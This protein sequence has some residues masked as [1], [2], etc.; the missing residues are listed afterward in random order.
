MTTKKPKRAVEWARCPLVLVE[1]IGRSLKM[2]EVLAGLR[3]VCAAWRAVRYVPFA[4]S[5][6]PVLLEEF[7]SRDILAHRLQ[8]LEVDDMFGSAA[9]GIVRIIT[10]IGPS[11][12]HITLKA[13]TFSEALRTF[14]GTCEI[15]GEEP[16]E[17]T[18]NALQHLSCCNQLK[19]T[20]VHF[21]ENAWS[22][23]SSKALR[24]LSLSLTN[25]ENSGFVDWLASSPQL[26]ELEFWAP[27]S[28]FNAKE[29]QLLEA[30][31]NLHTLER[32]SLVWDVHAFDALVT[33]FATGKFNRSLTTLHLD[34][35]GI[36]TKTE[37]QLLDVFAERYSI[38]VELHLYH[39]HCISDVIRVPQVSRLTVQPSLAKRQWAQVSKLALLPKLEALCLMHAK[40]SKRVNAPTGLIASLG[41]LI[42]M[43]SLIMPHF[44][45]T[46][47]QAV[48][49]F[50]TLPKLATVQETIVCYARSHLTGKVCVLKVE[51]KFMFSETN[52]EESNDTSDTSDVE[53]TC[54]ENILDT[55]PVPPHKEEK[56]TNWFAPLSK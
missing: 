2:H 1:E 45:V 6:D 30:L 9:T 17:W 55:L 49:L 25:L 41:A 13:T 28:M 47:A 32:L 48:W 53:F 11:L 56:I 43:E 24:K 23:F 54:D 27:Y 10:Y 7:M 21:T 5:E 42:N 3:H 38:L 39:M 33:L 19:F 37:R 44:I 26:L 35:Y 31:A 16:V 8:K 12:Q 50:D 29:K 46:P 36:D 20:N 4:W 40:G 52:H 15:R 51:K 18:A 22:M 14:T 34:L